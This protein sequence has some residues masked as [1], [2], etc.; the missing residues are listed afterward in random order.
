MFFFAIAIK[1]SLKFQFCNNGLNQ[2]FSRKHRR[3]IRLNSTSC[4]Q[5]FFVSIKEYNR[6]NIANGAQIQFKAKSV[7]SFKN[8]FHPSISR[9]QMR[10]SAEEQTDV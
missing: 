6:N 2:T 1:I 8:N 5:I 3:V 7:T 4:R 9:W 10:Y